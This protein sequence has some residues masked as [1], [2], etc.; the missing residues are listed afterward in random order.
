M[1][2]IAPKP[3][4]LVAGDQRHQGTTTHG[5]S[6][7][8]PV[9]TPNAAAQVLAPS[10]GLVLRGPGQ[11]GKSLILA[12]VAHALGSADVDAATTNRDI[13]TPATIIEFTNVVRAWDVDMTLLDKLLADPRIPRVPADRPRRQP[14]AGGHP[15]TQ[16]SP[17]VEAAE[18][19]NPS[20][21]KVMS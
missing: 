1:L 6:P 7:R 14:V 21:W 15:E 12:A 18:E 2:V 20:W 10:P 4:R 5:S 17:H 16:S 19:S 13:A 3:D 11:N 8:S 9:A